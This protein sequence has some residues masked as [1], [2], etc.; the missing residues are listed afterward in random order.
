[1]P[2]GA[3]NIKWL[4]PFDVDSESFD[5]HYTYLDTFGRP[6]LVLKKHNVVRLH[7]QHFQ[8]VYTYSNLGL[9][10]KPFLLISIFLL[11][12]GLSILYSRL[13]LNISGGESSSG[14]VSKRPGRL[15]QLVNSITASLPKLL[16]AYQS[17]ALDTIN[18]VDATRQQIQS[19][20]SE[21]FK[22][23]ELGEAAR[24]LDTLITRLKTDAKAYAKT[25]TDSKSNTSAEE[26][27]ETRN[28]ISAKIDEA[29][30]LLLQLV[31]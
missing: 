14:L 17:R 11:F 10:R 29:E 1:L 2:E 23:G 12:F 16:S 13:D 15:G 22:D 20:L 6:V 30:Q 3:G 31:K 9:L 28:R 26:L 7:N 21:L 18:S 27:A 8:V 25:S 19:A 24:Q 4:S 5:T